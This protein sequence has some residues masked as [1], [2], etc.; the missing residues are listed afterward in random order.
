MSKVF[1]ILV[2][3]AGLAGGVAAGVVLRPVVE[4]E[5][6][7]GDAPAPT[8]AATA[9]RTDA[10]RRGAEA[11][12][13]REQFVIPVIR[14]GAV[15]SLMVVALAI[16]VRGNMTEEVFAKEPRLRDAFL[17][18][19]FDHANSGGFDGVFTANENMSGLRTGLHE[20]AIGILGDTVEGVLITEL[21]RS[22]V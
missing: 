12:R 10:P 3:L 1:S 22:D 18:V 5:R 19:M 16:E 15:R 17:Q 7:V 9:A 11:V 13:L 2:I 8:T 21:F 20:A 4:P 6:Q 14:G